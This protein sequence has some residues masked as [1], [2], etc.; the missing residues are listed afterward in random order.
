MPVSFHQHLAVDDGRDD[1]LGRLLD[2]FGAGWEV[3][4]DFEP[5]WPHRVGIELG[6][7]PGAE[8]E[9][10]LELHMRAAVRQPD[11]RI[12]VKSG[13][14]LSPPHRDGPRR[15]GTRSQGSSRQRGRKRIDNAFVPHLLNLP[16]SLAFKIEQAG[17]AVGLERTGGAVVKISDRCDQ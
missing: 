16:D 3:V 4:N 1:A 7:Q 13:S 2:A 8:A 11:D 14:A 9:A 10:A 5:Q 6:E 17:I 15:A 12:R